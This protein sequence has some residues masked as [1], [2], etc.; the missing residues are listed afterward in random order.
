MSAT[1]HG[2]SN[3]KVGSLM[4]GCQPGKSS[5]VCF[6]PLRSISEVVLMMF[7]WRSLELEL[8]LMNWVHDGVGGGIVCMGT[9]R[10]K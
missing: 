2:C 8:T 3:P 1:H 4:F 5:G 7:Y 9:Y 10:P 6:M